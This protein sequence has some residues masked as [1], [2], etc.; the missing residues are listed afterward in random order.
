MSAVDQPDVKS[1][2]II[3]QGNLVSSNCRMQARVHSV[4]VTL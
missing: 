1:M 4:D 2:S 3:W